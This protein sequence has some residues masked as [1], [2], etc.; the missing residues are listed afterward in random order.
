MNG[1]ITTLERF[2]P[3][4]AAL[5][6]GLIGWGQLTFRVQANEVTAAE[7]AEKSAQDHDLLIEVRADQKAMKEKVDGMDDKLDKLL[8]QKGKD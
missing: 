8:E 7:T 3:V 5:G 2:W 1:T 4:M 6:L